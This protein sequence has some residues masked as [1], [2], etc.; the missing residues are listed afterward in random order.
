MKIENN[1]N[2]DI[3]IN[4]PYSRINILTIKSNHEL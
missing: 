2:N 3:N 1:I 4:Y